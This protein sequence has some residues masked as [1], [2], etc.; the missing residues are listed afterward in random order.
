MKKADYYGSLFRNA[1]KKYIRENSLTTDYPT[2][3]GC[4][5]EEAHY[6]IFD[7][8]PDYVHGLRLLQDG[9][10]YRAKPVLT[11]RIG[12]D[13]HAYVEE[14]EYTDIYMRRGGEIRTVTKDSERIAV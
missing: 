8:P 7:L 3:F 1:F 9:P 11:A 10:E 4:N 13:G 12:S 6:G 5:D 14:T 2:S